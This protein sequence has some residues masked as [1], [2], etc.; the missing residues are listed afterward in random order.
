MFT[1]FFKTESQENKKL[2][3][4]GNGLGLYIS[5]KICLC[6]GGDLKCQSQLQMGTTM[7]MTFKVSLRSEIMAK[8]LS[9]KPLLDDV[10]DDSHP[11]PVQNNAAS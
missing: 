3:P 1:K 8:N 11:M 5:R 6:M 2:N 9:F 10:Y 7:Q 4:N